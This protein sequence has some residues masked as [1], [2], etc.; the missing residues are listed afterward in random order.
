MQAVDIAPAI[1]LLPDERQRLIGEALD[2]DGKVLATDLARFLNTSEDT[3]RRDLREM[4]KAGLC[5]R[6][7]GGAL[8]VSP[9]SGTIAERSGRNVQ[10]KE[11]LAKA[12]AGL[13]R[14]NQTIFIDAG[15]TNAAIARALPEGMSLT[16]A[17][18]APMIAASLAGR[19]GIGVIMIGGRVDPHSGACL[20]SAAMR[21]AERIRPDLCFLGTCAVDTIEG[22][23]TFDFDEAEFKRLLAA[24]S[25]RVV[26]VATREKLHTGAPHKVME[27]ADLGILVADGPADDLDAYRTLGITVVTPNA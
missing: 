20:G 9:A 6:V 2:R 16:V 24:R 14:A 5:R 7:Y 13:V 1:A 22:V 27:A 12:A 18:N 26:A 11:R 10:E 15:S 4:A 17:T 3:I 8:P 21:E 23:T 19:E 25:R